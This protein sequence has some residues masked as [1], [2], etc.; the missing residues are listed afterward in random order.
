[1]FTGLV[2]A[3]GTIELRGDRV[4]I[5]APSSFFPLKLGESISVDGVCLTVA[6]LCQGAFLADMSEETLQ[7]TVLGEKAIQKGLVNLEPAIRLSDRL[8]GHLV[9]GHVDGFGKVVSIQRL[10]KSWN[11]QIC[12]ENH[13]FAKYTC[14]KAS[15][16]LNGV[17]LTVA[18]IKDEGQIFSSAIIPHTWENTSLHS[19]QEGELINLEADLVAK[20]VEGLLRKESVEVKKNVSNIS[21]DWLKINGFT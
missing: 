19:L 9:S 18:E 14:E 15:I 11:L 3:V 21:M 4:L 1:M 10:S 16:A 2:Q 12:W 17:S 8:G 20:Y 6:E 7:R 5:E 13:L